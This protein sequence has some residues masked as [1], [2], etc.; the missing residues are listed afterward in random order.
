VPS[1]RRGRSCP[2]RGRAVDGGDHHGAT[3]L[4]GGGVQE[5]SELA[6]LLIPAGEMRCVGEKLVGARSA[7]LRTYVWR[8]DRSSLLSSSRARSWM[9]T[10]VNVPGTIPSSAS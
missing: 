4:H 7:G 9:A 6:E 10:N 3:P 2:S 5:G 8:C 1:A